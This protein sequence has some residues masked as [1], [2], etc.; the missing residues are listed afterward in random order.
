MALPVD[1][2][3]K[4][5]A[6]GAQAHEGRALSWDDQGLLLMTAGLPV[7]VA[8]DLSSASEGREP[9]GR[10]H[11]GSGRSPDGGRWVVS[12]SL[13]VLVM[14]SGTQ[15]QLWRCAGMSSYDQ[16]QSC[17]VA[18]GATAL[19]CVEGMRTRVMVP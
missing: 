12:T 2:W 6:R 19:A 17:A 14:G 18:N 4:G 8:N 11:E 10:P 9:T 15:P 13:G 16:L 1:A 5:C 7:R 3:T